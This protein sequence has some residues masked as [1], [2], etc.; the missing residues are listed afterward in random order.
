MPINEVM[1]ALL[2]GADMFQNRINGFVPNVGVRQFRT[3]VVPMRRDA[4]AAQPHPAGRC[5]SP[6]ST[7]R[8][9]IGPSKST[10][11][12]SSSTRVLRRLHLDLYVAARV[13][14]LAFVRQSGCA[15]GRIRRESSA[16]F[17]QNRTSGFFRIFPQLPRTGLPNRVSKG[18]LRGK[19]GLNRRHLGWP[20]GSLDFTP[21]P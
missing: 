8:P 7:R 12:T 18:R 19:A 1:L 10:S 13:P 16:I 20:A 5:R 3:G 15:G 11:S 17:R 4:A 14:V 21:E 9:R 6:T 2:A